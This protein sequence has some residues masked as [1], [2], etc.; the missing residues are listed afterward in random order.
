MKLEEIDVIINGSESWVHIFEVAT[1][2]TGVGLQYVKGNCPHDVRSLTT[3][4]R[5]EIEHDCSKF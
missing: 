5:K 4:F 3:K 1:Y 2:L